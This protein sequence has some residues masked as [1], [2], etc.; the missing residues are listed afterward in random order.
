MVV[1]CMTKVLNVELLFGTA[2]LL[3]ALNS[4]PSLNLARQNLKF[5]TGL[6]FSYHG[7]KNR[8]LESHCY[9]HRHD[10]PCSLGLLYKQH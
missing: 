7:T 2:V 9:R 1:Y 10:D 5:E 6:S 8:S 4:I 3:V